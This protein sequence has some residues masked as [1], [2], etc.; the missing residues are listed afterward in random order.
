MI[1][2]P[3]YNHMDRVMSAFLFP[4]SEILWDHT[5]GGLAPSNDHGCTTDAVGV[6]VLPR[7]ARAARGSDGT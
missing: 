1:L 6:G 3:K 7:A 4:S 5:T 2:L